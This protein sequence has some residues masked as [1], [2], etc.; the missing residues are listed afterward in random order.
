M[1]LMGIGEFARLSRLSPKALRLYDELGLLAPTRVDPGS[2]YR[3]YTAGQLD[4]ARLVATLRQLAVPLAQIAVLL[5]LDAPAAAE[6]ITGFW[7]AAEA[8]HAARRE[9]AEHLVDRLNGKRI[10]MYEVNVRDVPA[11][12][13][14]SLLRHAQPEDLLPVGREF[15]ARMRGKVPLI[16]GIAGAP[17]VIYHGQVNADSDGPIEWCWPVPEDRAAEIA[18]Q[19]PDLTLRSETA[20][21]EAFVH[22]GPAAQQSSAQVELAVESLMHWA[23]E[24]NRTASGPLRQVFRPGPGTGGSAGATT[25]V[26]AGTAGADEAAVTGGAL[27][28][29]CDLAAPLR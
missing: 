29:V 16:E 18:A 24:H 28:P 6:R 10:T 20:H 7:A 2:G 14:L 9:L 12:S 13:L 15:I 27:G 26:T 1:D 5:D 25:E 19:Y 3:W 8:D 21:Q 4:R 17:F 23:G 22:Q 11:R